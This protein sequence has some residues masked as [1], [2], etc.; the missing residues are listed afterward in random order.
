MLVAGSSS[1]R[2]SAGV[3]VGLL[4]DESMELHTGPGRWHAFSGTHAFALIYDDLDCT[5]LALFPSLSLCQCAKSIM[6]APHGHVC[7][8]CLTTFPRRTRGAATAHH[9]GGLGKSSTT[10]TA[11]ASTFDHL[12]LYDLCFPL[13]LTGSA[14]MTSH[15]PFGPLESG[16]PQTHPLD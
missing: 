9:S 14:N 6:L 16:I 1:G 4:Y 5:H 2:H 13:C 8:L 15:W 12:E 10:A 3:L 11:F 7:P